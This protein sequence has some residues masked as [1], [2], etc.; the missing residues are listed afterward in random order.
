[1]FYTDYT[2]LNQDLIEDLEDTWDAL[3]QIFDDEHLWDFS[4]WLWDFIVC[5]EWTW[6][7]YFLYQWTLQ[8]WDTTM[9]SCDTQSM[10]IND[11]E[12]V[13]APSTLIFHITVHNLTFILLSNIWFPIT[14]L[15]TMVSLVSQLSVPRMLFCSPSSAESSHKTNQRCVAGKIKLFQLKEKMSDGPFSNFSTNNII[16]PPP[17]LMHKMSI[18]TLRCQLSTESEEREEEREC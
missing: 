15:V 12:T 18:L 9:Q 13:A 5:C 6:I 1:M 16:L 8:T 17:V 10:M 11:H 4:R 2:G 3:D 7:K 14:S